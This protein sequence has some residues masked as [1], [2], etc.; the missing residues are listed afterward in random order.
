MSEH[1]TLP[2]LPITGGCQ[3]G[4]VRYEL[5]GTP[6]VS[7]ICHCTECQKQSSSAFGQGLRV[8][9][10]DLTITGAYETCNHQGDSGNFVAGDFCPKCGTRLFHRRPEYSETR[11]IK[12]GTLDDTSWLKPAGHI[13]TASKQSW[14]NIPADA[15]NYLK[16][17][18]N[19]D[20]IIARWREMIAGQ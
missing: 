9:N 1:V 11:N 10:V 14:V 8:Q 2:K 17:P 12:A 16:Q 6:V 3:C 5:N 7:Y 20:A 15:I 4:A 19:F 13:W 18:K